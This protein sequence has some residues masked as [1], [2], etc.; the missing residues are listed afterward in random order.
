MKMPPSP[1]VQFIDFQGGLDLESPPLEAAPGDLQDSVN[2]D[3]GTTGGYNRVQG[4]E[5]YDG[6][7]IATEYGFYSVSMT[8]ITPNITLNSPVT[9]AATGASGKVIYFDD[10]YLYYAMPVGV[11]NTGDQLTVSGVI[12]GN[13]LEAPYQRK[14]RSTLTGALCMKLS[15]DV[16]RA[17]IGVV[18]GSGPIRGLC[19]YNSALYAFRNTVGSAACAIY[20]ATATG[21]SAV[22]LPA[23]VAFTAGS[24]TLVEGTT[25]TKG[26][27]T[28]PILRVVVESGS[29]G[30]G[31]AAG[32]LIIGTV[33]GGAFTAGA[34]T[35]P[36]ATLT[37][38][39]ASSAVTLSP[40]G[41]FRFQLYN[42]GAGLRMYAAYGTG[43]AFEFDGAVLVPIKTGMAVDTPSHI[44]THKNHLFLSF[45]N[46]LQHSGISNPYV[47][48]AV[49]GAAE[50]NMGERITN[51]LPQPSDSG[52]GG[53]MAV[54]TRNSLYV[55][56]GT[57][58]ANWNLVTLQKDVGSFAHSM[59]QIA[60]TSFFLDDR[61]VSSL[62]SVKEFGNFASATVSRRVRS[63]LM[64]RKTDLLDS[65]VVKEKNQMRLFFAGGTGMHITFDGVN[66]SG[67]MPV[68]YAHSITIALST[69]L[70]DGTDATFYGDDSGQVFI[71]DKGPSFSGSIITAY[72]KT[73]YNH[74]KSPRIIKRFRK[75][76]LEV[77]GAGYSDFAVGS[78]LGYGT[79]DLAVNPIL[80]ADVEFAG[81]RWDTPGAAWDSGVWDGRV[82]LPVEVPLEG[83]AE[84]L[85]ITVYQ[86][87]DKY[88]S[89]QFQGA[90][91]QYQPRR[92]QR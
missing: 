24:G 29:L 21:W 52:S 37:L 89:L 68:Q 70:G 87:S 33:T 8:F 78:E 49:L 11:F 40:N 61:G 50:L 60:A 30:A 82:L 47:W 90:L 64:E 5:L 38:S 6:T 13:V 28:A 16:Y 91:L 15:A 55:L 75:M 62:N 67:F 69:E 92:I 48:S 39:G 57:S 65:C 19:Y 3:I 23:Q 41:R 79:Y 86:S 14:D 2:F 53:A 35:A 1:S 31:T 17:A 26:G 9:C 12:I 34:A 81:P 80:P 44:A 18:P 46:S 10:T 54:S 32:K 27:V 58:A 36:G 42:F 74:C 20:K 63:W 22:S 84:N 45:D 85:S 72:F 43:P 88:E 4:Y 83:S 56:Y 25:L 7:Q 73:H 66:P 76:T 71:A 51:L 77:K 59:Q